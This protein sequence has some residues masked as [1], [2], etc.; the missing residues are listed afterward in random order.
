MATALKNNGYL[1][2]RDVIGPNGLLPIGR[3]NWY[4]RIANE[5]APRPVKC[6]RLNLW[7]V[8]DIERLLLDPDGY[9][10]GEGDT[11]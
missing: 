9:V 7:K 11:K 5:R 2:L 10:D 6:G 8:A 3:S 1:R 4:G